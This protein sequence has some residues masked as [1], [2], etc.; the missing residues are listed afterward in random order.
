MTNPQFHIILNGEDLKAF[1]LRSGTKQECSLLSLLFNIVLEVLVTAI[2]QEK[3]IQ[4][5]YIGKEGVKLSLFADKIVL[6]L[7]NPK[8]A[9]IKRSSV[10][11]IVKLQD[12]KLIYG[13]LLH[14][15]ILTTNG[16]KE[17]YFLTLVFLNNSIYNYIKKNKTPR[18]KYADDTTLM[19]ESEEAFKK[20]LDESERG[21]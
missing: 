13:N 1:L 2:G 21:E 12:T 6:Y 10:S 14:F 17:N 18:N 9:T 16:E 8:D 3:E 20:P 5:I 19:A 11:G 15:Y 7:E 4:G